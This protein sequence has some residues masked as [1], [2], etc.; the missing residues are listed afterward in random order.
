[1]RSEV[2]G[3]TTRKMH[4]DVMLFKG[5]CQ[6]V[7]VQIDLGGNVSMVRGTFATTYAR[8]PYS[9]FQTAIRTCAFTTVPKSRTALSSPCCAT[10]KDST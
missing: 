3:F 2:H 5:A 10:E 7:S 6:K 4:K 9:S 8:I 1:M